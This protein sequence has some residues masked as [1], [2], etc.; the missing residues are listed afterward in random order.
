MWEKWVFLASSAASTSLMRAPISMIIWHGARRG[1]TSLL[2]IL[3]QE[4]KAVATAEGLSAPRTPALERATGMLTTEGSPLTAS[5]FRDIK[6]GQ[7]VE[8]DHVIGDP[9]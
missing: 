4:C 8:A 3:E 2:G 9:D 5:M 1:R 6:A 7:P